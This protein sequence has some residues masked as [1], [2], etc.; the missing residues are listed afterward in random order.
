MHTC[1][2]SGSA[3]AVYGRLSNLSSSLIA[4]LD[5]WNSHRLINN[6]PTNSGVGNE[7]EHLIYF[8][9]GL[10]DTEHELQISNNPSWDAPRRNVLN[11]TN[12]ISIRSSS[13]TSDSE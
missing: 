9:S 13:I 2:T 11:I 3:V 10:E 4:T 1:P 8:V 5:S 7:T 12:A 6:V